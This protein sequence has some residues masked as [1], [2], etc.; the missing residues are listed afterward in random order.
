MRLIVKR[1]KVHLIF[2][3]LGVSFCGASVW[4][5]PGESSQHQAFASAQSKLAPVSQILKLEKAKVELLQK[6]QLDTK[7]RRALAGQVFLN[8]LGDYLK[9]SGQTEE[10][11]KAFVAQVQKD[12]ARYV[13]SFRIEPQSDTEVK[14]TLTLAT[15]SLLAE[16]QKQ[17]FS[18]SVGNVVPAPEPEKAP[19]Y[20]ALLIDE[21][22]RDVYVHP[23]EALTQYALESSQHS[24][25]WQGY[26]FKAAVKLKAVAPNDVDLNSLTTPL[27]SRLSLF[28]NKIL[29]HLQSKGLV[30]RNEFTRNILSFLETSAQLGISRDVNP[31]WPPALPWTASAAGFEPSLL[32]ACSVRSD[33]KAGVLEKIE[34]LGTQK[35]RFLRHYWSRALHDPS[36]QETASKALEKAAAAFAAQQSSKRPA[37]S[38]KGLGFWFD[39]RIAEKEVIAVESI[40]RTFALGEDSLLLPTSVTKED[41]RYQSPVPAARAEVVLDRIRKGVRGV[42][43]KLA[44]GE[45]PVIVLEPELG[46]TAKPQ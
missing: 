2:V 34:I 20:T 7:E 33:D 24:A 13:P 17:G 43:A 44:S 37:V 41:V 40:L 27:A 14:V 8:Y 11:K 29:Y 42:R 6:G 16:V 12:F 22:S 35:G 15:G 25:E 30:F 10:K 23:A 36:Y 32:V 26:R 4:T 38:T 45:P 19:A 5:W 46:T 3:S 21:K 39:K 1:L 18:N 28:S 9:T 31:L